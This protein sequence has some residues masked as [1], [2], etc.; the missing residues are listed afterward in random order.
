MAQGFSM[1]NRG[2]NLK[3]SLINPD[4]VKEYLVKVENDKKQTNLPQIQSQN[5]QLISLED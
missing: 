5:D 4:R 1:Y 2:M 3:K